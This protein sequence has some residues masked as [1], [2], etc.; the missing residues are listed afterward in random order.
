MT[1]QAQRTEWALQQF[2][3]FV[4]AWA[5]PAVQNDER[6]VAD[7]QHVMRT[8]T[9]IAPIGDAVPVLAW[10]VVSQRYDAKTKSRFKYEVVTAVFEDIA[11]AQNA[12]ESCLERRSE[13]GVKYFICALREVTT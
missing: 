1:D 11:Q 4:E 9:A 8:I 10:V 13:R 12:Y 7:V 2:A 3:G 5:P 6:L